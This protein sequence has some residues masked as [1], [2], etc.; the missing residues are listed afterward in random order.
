MFLKYFDGF[1]IGSNDLTQLTLGTDRAS[2]ILAYGFDEMDPAVMTLIELAIEGAKA[3]KSYRG[4]CGQGPSDHPDF[5]KWLLERKIDS[6]SLNPDTVR[7]TWKNL[8]KK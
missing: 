6:M 1:S 8:S 5:A 4:S 2:G 7:S 3:S